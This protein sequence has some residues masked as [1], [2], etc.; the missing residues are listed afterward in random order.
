MMNLVQL[1]LLRPSQHDP[2]RVARRAAV[3]VRRRAALRRPPP[4]HAVP[5]HA[6]RPTQVWRPSTTGPFLIRRR[7]HMLGELNGLAGRLTHALERLERG[8]HPASLQASGRFCIARSSC[9]SDP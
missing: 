9:H 8:E 6:L 5:F 2:A 3:R 1:R 4:S 7:E